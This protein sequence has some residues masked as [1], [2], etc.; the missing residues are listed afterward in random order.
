MSNERFKLTDSFRLFL[1][2]ETEDDDESEDEEE[3]EAENQRVSSENAPL[4]APSLASGAPR[5]PLA[6]NLHLNIAANK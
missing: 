3:E 2:L 4:A 1:S 6:N 5:L